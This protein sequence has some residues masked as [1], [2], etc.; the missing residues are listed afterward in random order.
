MSLFGKKKDRGVVPDGA[1]VAEAAEAA[2]AAAEAA[3]GVPAGGP[4]GGAEPAA[5]DGTAVVATAGPYDEAEAPAGGRLIDLGSIRVPVRQGMAL[6]MEVDRASGRAISVTLVHEGAT[7][8]VQ[9]FAA[10]RTL[11][12][13]D[14]IRSDLAKQAEKAGGSAREAQGRFGAELLAELPAQTA[15]GRQ[16]K[17]KVRFIG[18]DGPRWFLRGAIGG[19]PDDPV[20]EDVF[21]GIVVVRGSDAYPPRE[22]LPL[23]V[24]G[25]GKAQAP[26]D[27][28]LALLKRGPEITEVR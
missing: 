8:Q 10:P 9:A 4:A 16:G 23:K 15:D 7:L 24:P 13:W 27:D 11:G 28:P 21:A 22:L 20:L 17:R 12:V 3:A 2:E 25:A 19:K 26:Q 14:D 5:A 6:R 1:G 18:V